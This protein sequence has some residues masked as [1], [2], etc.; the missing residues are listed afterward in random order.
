M[1]SLS[2]TVCRVSAGP[3]AAQKTICSFGRC[4]EAPRAGMHSRG[5]SGS[6]IAL[7]AGCRRYPRRST[8]LI[9]QHAETTYQHGELITLRHWLEALPNGGDPASA[10]SCV[11]AACSD[12]YW[13]SQG[14]YRA[15]AA[16]LEEASCASA[17]GQRGKG[18]VWHSDVPT[19]TLAAR[20]LAAKGGSY[21]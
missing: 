8:K 4:S 18:A 15:A 12:V 21:L 19:R 9:E 3:L 1:V 10:H 17:A 5:S 13:A 14:M 7:C 2:S 11:F 20:I 6:A 16:R